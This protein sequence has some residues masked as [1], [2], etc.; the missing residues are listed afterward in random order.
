M[1]NFL[2]KREILALMVLVTAGLLTPSEGHNSEEFHPQLLKSLSASGDTS[3]IGLEPSTI[4][5]L[6]LKNNG[7]GHP[8]GFP[9]G[10]RMIMKDFPRRMESVIQGAK[11]NG[12]GKKPSSDG[13]GT[14]PSYDSEVIAEN[15]N[16]EEMAELT[17]ED[18]KGI[19]GG[20][21][22]TFVLSIE[23]SLIVVGLGV[24][25]CVVAYYARY[26][27][28]FLDNFKTGYK[29]GEDEEG[30][31]LE[32]FEYST[33]NKNPKAVQDVRHGEKRRP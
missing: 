32:L 16:E 24:L 29:R 23:G 5:A 26:R 12:A 33:K 25:W 22:L 1:N 30:I 7:V 9:H 19:D 21:I 31:H 17:T 4:R 6:R 3:H 11:E 8:P 15:E 2:Y 13:D 20:I 10:L 18:P 14:T 28:G 27:K